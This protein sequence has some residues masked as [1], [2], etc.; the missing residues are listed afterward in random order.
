MRKILLLNQLVLL[1][2]FSCLSQENEVR[3]EKDG[4]FYIYAI[5]NDSIEGRFI[6]D[7]GASGLYLDSTFVERHGSII[8]SNPDTAS[9]RGAGATDYRQVLL[10]KDTVKITVGSL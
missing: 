7:T 8:K 6:L 5:I 2:L 10:V 3:F 4:S 1:T 9:M